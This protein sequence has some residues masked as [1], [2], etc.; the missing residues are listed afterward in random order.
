MRINTWAADAQRL[1]Q[2]KDLTQVRKPEREDLESFET[3]YNAACASLARG[4]LKQG[5]ILL[6]RAKELCRTSEDLSPEDKELE[7]LPIAIQQLYALVSQGKTEEAEEIAKEISVSDISESSTKNIAQNNILITQHLNIN[8]YTI[9]KTFHDTPEPQGNDKLFEF[10]K[11]AFEANSHALDLTVQ[12]YD[13][14][15]R[16]TTKALAQRAYPSTDPN[17]NLLSIYNAAARVR[18][19]T[20]PKSIQELRALLERRPKDIGLV[21]TIVQLYSGQGNITSAINVLESS[22]KSLDES[23]SETDQAVRYNPGLISVLIA[24]YQREGRKSHIKSELAKAASFWRNNAP[25]PHSL[26][27]AAGASLLHS[28]D[29]AHLAISQGLFGMLRSQ[30]PNDKFALAG[31]VASYATSDLPKVQNELNIL[32]RSQDLVSD[33][34]VAALESAGVAQSQASLAAHAAVIAGARKRASKEQQHARAKKRIRTSRLPKDY[35]ASKKPDAERWLPLRDRSSYRPRGKKGKQ[36]AAE[37][38]QGGIVS[39]DVA[40][41]QQQQKSGG[42]GTSSK[43]K[44]GKR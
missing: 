22:L 6:K 17:V 11:N 40:A 28:S 23:V 19:E 35:D 5:E 31:Y 10:Q 2:R 43:K 9:Y 34:D 20:T 26:L 18:G 13:G 32:P 25:Q 7:L 33:I 4:D 38:T 39:D 24:L 14:V 12:K 29:P 16:S 36:R 42:G 15:I 37:R 41:K 30:N 8:P 21:L 3:A 27:R 1:W 44:K